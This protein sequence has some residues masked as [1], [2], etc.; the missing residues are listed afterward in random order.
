MGAYCK[1]QKLKTLL[2]WLLLLLWILILLWYWLT[3]KCELTSI[4]VSDISFLLWSWF[5]RAL[6]KMNFKFTNEMDE[7]PPGAYV[8]L[9]DG[10]ESEYP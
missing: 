9:V 8:V 3:T 10:L 4:R 5:I 7:F 2:L 1:I 6:L